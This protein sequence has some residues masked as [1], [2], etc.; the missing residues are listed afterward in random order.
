MM[1]GSFTDDEDYFESD[2]SDDEPYLS[3]KEEIRQGN[4]HAVREALDSGA[5]PN[6]YDTDTGNYTVLHWAAGMTDE[7]NLEEVGARNRG[8][9]AKEDRVRIVRLL[10]DR[11]ATAWGIWWQQN[12]FGDHTGQRTWDLTEVQEVQDLLQTSCVQQVLQKIR[13]GDEDLSNEAK[14]GG[15]IAAAALNDVDALR[16]IYRSGAEVDNDSCDV[17]ALS[18]ASARGNIEAVRVLVQECGASVHHDINQYGRTAL[19]CAAEND[20]DAIVEFL[21][22]RGANPFT[23]QENMGPVAM[24]VDNAETLAILLRAMEDKILREI[25]VEDGNE[26][27]SVAR[28]V[29]YFKLVFD[30]FI[31]R[32]YN[33]GIQTLISRNIRLPPNSL[34]TAVAFGQLDTLELLLAEGALRNYDA[35]LKCNFYGPGSCMP[36]ESVVCQ[37][38]QRLEATCAASLEWAQL[39]D[40]EE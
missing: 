23:V 33:E 5:D 40:R 2:A 3:L 39:A 1:F 24:Q 34:Q 14:S 22:N 9:F 21:L 27:Y 4:L 12:F 31:A 8:K 30:V 18:T 13:R 7:D 16:E 10:L 20:H 37:C 19:N 6:E 28:K 35:T 11:G 17:T 29:H 26:Y 32:G 15:L 36:D 38:Q 25:V